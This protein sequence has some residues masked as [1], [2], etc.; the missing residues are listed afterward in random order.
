SRGAVSSTTARHSSCCSGSTSRCTELPDRGGSARLAPPPEAP[1]VVPQQQE[2]L[3]DRHT[4]PFSPKLREQLAQTPA[5]RDVVPERLRE[6]LLRIGGGVGR[7]VVGKG[8]R[9]ATTLEVHPLGV[10]H[11]VRF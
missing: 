8:R 5:A 9:D 7:D 10:R 11:P 1:H 6:V 4:L 3:E 2:L